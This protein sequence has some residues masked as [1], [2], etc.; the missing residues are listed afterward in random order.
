MNFVALHKEE[1]EN[2]IQHLKRELVGL[3]TG[4]ATPALVEDVSVDAYGTRQPLKTLASISVTDA[5]TLTIEPWDKSILLN[6][7]TAIRSAQQLGLNPVNDGKLIRLPLP[8]LTQERRQ[9]LVKV[10]FQKLEQGRIAIRQVR[11]EA[12]KMIEEAEEAGD[13]GEDEKFNQLEALEKMVKEF[14]ERIKEIGEEK[15][16]EIQTI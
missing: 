9:E 13:I 5:K 1:F 4:R 10:L 3:R 2:G 12:R 11:E 8:E 15:E 6:V 14:N 7:E 16:K